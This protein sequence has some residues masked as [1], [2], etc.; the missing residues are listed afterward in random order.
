MPEQQIGKLR[1][2][3]PIELTVDAFPGQVFK[4][5]DP[6][7]R[8]ARGA[9]HAHAAG[10]RPAAQSG[11]QAAAGHVRQ[12]HRAGGRASR[13]R[14]R[15]AHRR[16]LQPLRRQRLRG[17]AGAGRGG[18]GR[19][20]RRRAAA[21]QPA[22]PALVVERRFVRTGQVREDRVA[23]TFGLAGRRAG[24]DHRPAQAQSG[25]RRSA[26]TT[27][28]RSTGPKSGRSNSGRPAMSFTDIFIRRPVLATVVSLLIL[29]IGLASLFNLPVRQYPED[30]QH[31]HHHHHRLSRRQRRP[32][33][34][35]HHHAHPAGGGQRRGHRHADLLLAAELQR[36]HPQPAPRCRPRP[37]RGR[38]AVEDP[39]GQEHAAA[40]VAGPDRHQADRRDHRAH[41]PVVQQQGDDRPRRSPTT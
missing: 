26:S 37:R 30:H 3:Q 10:A 12:R 29:L 1:V 28:S 25:R 32:H 21:S 19:A 39:A 38:R 24:R 33:Q 8:C 35:L 14:H 31:H 34:G 5:R 40:R 11:A 18:Q 6:V 2:G 4:R 9:G 13:R 17:E 15:A 41:V 16:H 27:P 23:I 36:R 20:P 7:A 22:E